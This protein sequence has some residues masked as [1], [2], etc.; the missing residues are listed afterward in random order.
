MSNKLFKTL[1]LTLI[2]IIIIPDV[3]DTFAKDNEK[4]DIDF[5]GTTLDGEKFYG[6]SLLGKIVLLDFFAIWC[7]PCIDAFPV[8]NRL[9]TDLKDS[10]LIVFSIAMYSGTIEDIKGITDAH[11]L[12]FTMVMG[13]D[14]EIAIRYRIIGFPTYALI[15][16]DGKIRKRYVGDR[17]DFYDIVSADVMDINR[18]YGR[19]GAIDEE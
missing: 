19:L 10:N 9:N 15:D 1:I 8:L 7:A 2:S 16:P 12:N 3:S 18:E 4:L 14:D 17:R 11:N 5:V 6:K 13:D